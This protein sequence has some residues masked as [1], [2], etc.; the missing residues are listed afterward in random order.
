MTGKAYEVVEKE[1]TETTG[2][3]GKLTITGLDWGK[4]Y[5]VETNPLTGYVADETKYDFEISKDELAQGLIWNLGTIINKKIQMIILPTNATSDQ[6]DVTGHRMRI[7]GRFQNPD[8]SFIE[9][10]ETEKGYVIA[11]MLLPGEIYTLERREVLP[12]YNSSK[13]FQFRYNGYGDVEIVS[14]EGTDIIVEEDGTVKLVQK[15]EPL[16]VRIL[17]VDEAGK[18]LAGAVLSLCVK[19]K[20]G[21]TIQVAEVTTNGSAWEL[22]GDKYRLLQVGAAC[23]LTEK[24]APEGYVL[25][26]DVAFTIE[27]DTKWQEYTMVDK[28]KQGGNTGSGIEKDPDNGTEKD[29]DNGTE[30][31]P[32]DGAEKNPDDETEKEPDN[33][34]EKNP[35]DG[36][37]KNPGDGTEKDS[38]DGTEKD[39]GDRTEKNPDKEKKKDSDKKAKKELRN[40][41]QSNGKNSNSA[42]RDGDDESDSAAILPQ[43]GREERAGFYVL[44]GMLAVVGMLMLL[45]G[46]RKK[47][48]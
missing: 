4:Y 16:K 5:I 20:S 22:T 44:G 7:S 24:S 15:V 21:A 13:E 10:K 26:E 45:Y 42:N 38:D 8:V 37:E 6:A 14:G 18:P 9:W 1:W 48:E 2:E 28:R 27:D 31:E 19:D 47:K 32:D 12:G 34:A 40:D 35:D 3:D 43:T 33:G 11:G 29:P 17:K 36:T 39:L 23:V 41:E 46:R 30:K 25:A